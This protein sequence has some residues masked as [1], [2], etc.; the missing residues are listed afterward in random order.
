MRATRPSIHYLANC[1]KSALESLELSR[2]NLAA[3]LRKQFHQ[4][5]SELIDH[6]VDA[7]L[8]RAIMD[9]RRAQGL[10]ETGD[11]IPL[12]CTHENARSL[13]PSPEQLSIAFGTAET[14][15]AFCP[16][17]GQAE[18]DSMPSRQ[19]VQAPS[20]SQH[21]NS[22]YP[23]ASQKHSLVRA[24]SAGSASVDSIADCQRREE[25]AG[26]RFA[27]RKSVS[28]SLRTSRMIERSTCAAVASHAVQSA[29][30]RPMSPAGVLSSVY[31][32]LLGPSATAARSLR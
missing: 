24:A 11:Q 2:L 6:E 31:P 27:R 17:A 23:V 14:E 12:T 22:P 3:N 30:P 1:S 9:W 8:A 7:R 25:F 21:S 4:V 19:P 20:N 26:T 28:G 16:D 29:R 32:M 5:L 18:R 15:R 13:L 10:P